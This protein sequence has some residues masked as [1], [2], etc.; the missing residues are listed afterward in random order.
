ML[1][2]QHRTRPFSHGSH[3]VRVEKES[4]CFALIRV[5]RQEPRNNK[6][7]LNGVYSVLLFQGLKTP[8]WAS[9]PGVSQTLGMSAGCM[10]RERDMSHS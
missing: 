9:R 2:E 7:T 3:P 10:S 1:Y 4:L 5:G 6:H 8:G